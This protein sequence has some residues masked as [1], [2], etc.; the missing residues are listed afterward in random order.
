MGIRK[1]VVSF[2]HT[3]LRDEETSVVISV[4]LSNAWEVDQSIAK[5]EAGEG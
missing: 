5:L 3:F 4:H 2:L 1:E